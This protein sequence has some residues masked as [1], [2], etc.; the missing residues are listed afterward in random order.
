MKNHNASQYSNQRN[1]LDIS[2][3]NKNPGNLIAQLQSTHNHLSSFSKHHIRQNNYLNSSNIQ[4]ISINES[5]EYFKRMSTTKNLDNTQ[6]S[7]DIS[8]LRNCES[9]QKLM[10]DEDMI[11]LDDCTKK[12]SPTF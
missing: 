3:F 10:G 9:L 4:N 6:R 1:S 11:V 2:H 12:V 7:R 8:I 5:S